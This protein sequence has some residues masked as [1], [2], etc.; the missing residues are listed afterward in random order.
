MLPP[1]WRSGMVH[2]LC[3]SYSKARPATRLTGA[4]AI[5]PFFFVASSLI[6][7]PLGPSWRL[8]P[9][10]GA[11][12]STTSGSQTFWRPMSSSLLAGLAPRLSIGLLCGRLAAG[13]VGSLA[14]RP[15]FDSVLIRKP[16]H[17]LWL[18][19]TVFR[20]NLFRARCRLLSRVLSSAN[21]ACQMAGAIRLRHLTRCY[22]SV[23]PAPYL[24]VYSALSLV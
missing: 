24:R 1:R 21:S 2:G 4:S 14:L 20:A 22:P 10:L 12:R 3:R 5:S 19:L 15:H 9:L 6:S 17:T 16:S 13:V 23:R 8:P 11:P 18:R 7:G